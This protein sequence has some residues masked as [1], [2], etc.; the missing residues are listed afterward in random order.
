M[1]CACGTEMEMRGENV[2]HSRARLYKKLYNKT[3][4]IR[5][6]V[7]RQVDYHLAC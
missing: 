6:R 1:D 3:Y 5:V 4:L 7:P 2:S